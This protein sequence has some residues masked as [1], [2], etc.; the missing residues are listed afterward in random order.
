[1]QKNELEVADDDKDFMNHCSFVCIVFFSDF[2]T[3]KSKVSHFLH[4]VQKTCMCVG[5]QT[6]SRF[7]QLFWIQSEHMKQ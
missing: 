5:Y 1:M 7:F 4:A 6:T 3:Q 2:G